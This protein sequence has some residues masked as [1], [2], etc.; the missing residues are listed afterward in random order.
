MKPMTADE[1][2]DT[3]FVNSSMDADMDEWLELEAQSCD[4]DALCVRGWD[5]P[6][7]VL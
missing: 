4:C 2:E 7:P 3:V 6:E 5:D 1:Y